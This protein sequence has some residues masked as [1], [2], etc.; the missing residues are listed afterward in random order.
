MIKSYEEL[1]ASSG[2]NLVE[3]TLFEDYAK[4]ELLNLITSKGYYILDSDQLERLKKFAKAKEAFR[5]NARKG[6]RK[7]L[8]DLTEEEFLKLSKDEQLKYKNR[9]WKRKSRNA[10]RLE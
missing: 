9:I 3:K 4:K 1:Q 2:R 8:P 6:G 7:K 5:E 10:S